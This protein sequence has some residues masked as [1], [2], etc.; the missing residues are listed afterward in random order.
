MFLLVPVLKLAKSFKSAANF[1][2]I[3]S[4]VISCYSIPDKELSFSSS[5]EPFFLPN[6]LYF[7]A[8]LMFLL[9]IF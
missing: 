3:Y 1:T 7:K 9:K 8:A 6:L 5:L 4:P 2:A